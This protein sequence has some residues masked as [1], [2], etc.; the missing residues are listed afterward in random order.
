VK[1][2]VPD[3]ISPSYFPAEA[4]VTLGFL[5]NEGIDA[6]IELISPIERAYDA[7]RN[8]EIDIVAGSA[9]SALSAFPR[10]KGV[11]LI[12]AQSQG[13]YWFLVM[14]ADLRAKRGDLSVV[15]GKRIGAA[16]W[17]GLCFRQLLIESGI[18]PERDGVT[19][20]P[21]PG[22]LDDK[23]NFGVAAARALEQGV[24]DG[25]WANGMGAEIAV[26]S[27]IGTL[28][29]DARRGDGPKAGFNYTMA[30]LA[31]T[32][33]LIAEQPEKIAGAV[34]AI[35]ATQLALQKDVQLAETVAAK[36]FP[37]DSSHIVELVRRDLPFYRSDLAPAFVEGM[38]R[39]ARAIN[40]LDAD[41]P[42]SEVVAEQFSEYW[43]NSAPP[44][45]S[46]D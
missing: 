32:D 16:P 11:K 30:T 5:A 22:S 40:I 23:V 31:T 4:A 24:I 29:L 26:R 19:I 38:N 3:L 7:L 8:G 41:V 33:K 27:G 12:C 39:F 20:M 2:A 1:I 45:V 10:W 34:R 6:Q 44:N 14:R 42:Y 13:M 15:K 18:D 21:T 36:L 28:V 17:V 43:N 35:A 46:R 37:Q 9:H 25:F